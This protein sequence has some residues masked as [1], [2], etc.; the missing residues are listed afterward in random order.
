[1]KKID[2]EDSMFCRN[3]YKQN[4][5]ERKICITR[6][7]IAMTLNDIGLMENIDVN[8]KENNYVFQ[9]L[10]FV[11]KK[12]S[13]RHNYL[14]GHDFWEIYLCLCRNHKTFTFFCQSK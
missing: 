11:C 13:E 14:C 2:H 10:F 3:E 8:D 7:V 9:S 4:D 6:I 5:F 12:R 1:M